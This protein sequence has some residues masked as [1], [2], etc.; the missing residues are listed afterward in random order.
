MC[1][2][3]LEAARQ[4]EFISEGRQIRVTL[5]V[6]GAHDSGG[7][8]ERT[9]F[10]DALLEGADEGLEEA[11][12]AG[13]NRAGFCPTG[14]CRS[15]RG[16]PLGGDRHGRRLRMRVLLAEDE[17]T[18]FVTLR[19]ALEDAGHEVIGATD[20]ASALKALELEP[21][22]DAVVTDVRMPGA[23]GLAILDRAMELDPERPV[24]L[25]TGYATVDDAVD[26]MRRGAV[27]YIQKPFRN[28]AVL[29]RLD[30][31]SRVSDL[32]EENRAL[33]EKLAAAGPTGIDGIIGSSEAMQAVFERVRT[34]AS[35]EA[36]VEIEGES[37]TGKERVARAIHDLSPRREGPFI[38]LGCGALPLDLLE[39]ELFGH[40]KGAFTD[41]QASA[42]RA[43]RARRRRD[44]VP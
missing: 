1:E 29:R 25:M 10:F 35:T 28:E 32:E 30:T 18:I 5:S 39:A 31:L 20:T 41:A 22:A 3:L 34:V 15:G 33:R 17:V 38:A 42:P 26:A 27:D 12:A 2:R 23:G 8:A 11:V 36:T 21:A 13:G 44:A 7:A 43:R 37:G 4:L 9:L 24:L 14:S 19:D 6:G 16:S 40:E